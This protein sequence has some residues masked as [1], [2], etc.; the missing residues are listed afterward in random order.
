MYEKEVGV[1]ITTLHTV[2]L[3][4]ALCQEL[5]V[6]LQHVAQRGHVFT[7]RQQLCLTRKSELTRRMNPSERSVVSVTYEKYAGSF[8]CG[9]LWE[10][11]GENT[12]GE[13]R[14]KL[15]LHKPRV[16]QVPLTR[17]DTDHSK[18]GRSYPAGQAGTNQAFFLESR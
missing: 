3:E 10:L 14:I 6:P 8:Y 16:T 18:T 1:C 17:D 11:E 13:Q 9:C 12:W 4:D 7:A 5:S 15:K 2:H